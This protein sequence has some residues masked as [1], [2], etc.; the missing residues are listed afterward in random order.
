MKILIAE[1][2]AFNQHLI[3]GALSPLGYELEFCLDGDDAWRCLGTRQYPVVIVGQELPG[4]S[5]LELCRRLRAQAS[6]RPVHL[7]V[8]SNDAS[9]EALLAGLAAGAN[10]YLFNPLDPMELRLRIKTAARQLQPYGENI[11]AA[12]QPELTLKQS[13]RLE[14]LLPVC[15]HCKSIRNVQQVW[16]KL[17]DFITQHTD[18]VCSHGICPTCA[19]S[20][21]TGTV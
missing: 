6:G 10:E 17:E 15:A 20:F 12:M 16:Q 18:A 5:G 2:D 7:V 21:K 19:G 3:R 13:K 11:D 14:G 9:Q 1:H 4:L 8:L